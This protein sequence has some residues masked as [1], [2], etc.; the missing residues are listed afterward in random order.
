MQTKYFCFSDLRVVSYFI[1]RSQNW[2]PAST[3]N[4]FGPHVYNSYGTEVDIWRASGDYL[5]YKSER[6]RVDVRLRSYYSNDG[7]FWRDVTGVHATAIEFGRPPCKVKLEVYSKYQT[8][9]EHARFLYNGKEIDWIDI[10]DRLS[11]CK[12]VTF[13]SDV[14]LGDEANGTIILHFLNYMVITIRNVENM[15]A[16]SITLP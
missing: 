2:C 5:M 3:C 9:H 13:C 4:A 8:E 14:L 7:E 10:A 11:S 16:I 15:H 1:G 6:M 12:N